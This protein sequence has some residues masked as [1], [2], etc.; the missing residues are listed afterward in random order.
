MFPMSEDQTQAV[1][2]GLK[3]MLK[4]SLVSISPYIIGEKNLSC[5]FSLRD[6]L[7]D[8][9]I[10][11]AANKLY[12]HPELNIRDDIEEIIRKLKWREILEDLGKEIVEKISKLWLTEEQTGELFSP[13]EKK[14]FKEVMERMEMDYVIFP[15]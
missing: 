9:M 2:E 13:E 1:L 6:E 11:V 14:R 10:G 4:C 15:F 7:I 12:H 5:W 3:R 8:A